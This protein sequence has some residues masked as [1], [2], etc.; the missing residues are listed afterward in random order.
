MSW[1]PLAKKITHSTAQGR[2]KEV[3]VTMSGEFF[4]PGPHHY[5]RYSGF[6]LKNPRPGY[7]VIYPCAKAFEWQPPPTS[8]GGVSIMPLPPPSTFH[9]VTEHIHLPGGNYQIG[10][11]DHAGGTQ[12]HLVS[13]ID[14]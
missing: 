11:C 13:V 6:E 1:S 2:A 7:Y 12:W 5:A 8:S 9:D 14:F 3:I 4:A 10:I